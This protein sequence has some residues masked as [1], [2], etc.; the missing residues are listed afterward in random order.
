MRSS[1]AAVS[2]LIRTD[3]GRCWVWSRTWIRR[4]LEP[5]PAYAVRS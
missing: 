3:H 4:A 2:G 5:V 1:P